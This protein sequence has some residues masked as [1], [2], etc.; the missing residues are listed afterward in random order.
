M[1]QRVQELL[2]ILTSEKDLIEELKETVGDRAGLT[3]RIN[4]IKDELTD[5][6][7]CLTQ[8]EKDFK[9]KEKDVTDLSNQIKLLHFNVFKEY[10]VNTEKAIIENLPN[11]IRGI[12]SDKE[13]DSTILK[14]IELQHV[15]DN[16]TVGNIEI[17]SNNNN[18]I[19]V[20]VRIQD[21]QSGNYSSEEFSLE[22]P[23]RVY[24][25]I[26]Y[27]NTNLNYNE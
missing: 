17:S 5:L 24:K 3:K 23:L 19:K 16:R 22:R 11:G 21:N 14:F 26:T 27:I 10:I 15:G 12:P 9:Q 20:G 13:Q 1:E 4:H 25:I 6:G 18:E 2:E 7:K 8:I